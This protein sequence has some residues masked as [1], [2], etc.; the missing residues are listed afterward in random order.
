[1]DLIFDF[2]S[3]YMAVLWKG[4]RFRVTGSTVDT[5]NGGSAELFVES[6]VLKLRVFCDRRQLM[7]DFASKAD[8][9]GGA[10]LQ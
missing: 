3:R 4:A 1:M 2:V 9:K 7:L 8:P 5:T 6:D 10:V